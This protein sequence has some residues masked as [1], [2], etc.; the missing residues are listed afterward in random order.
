VA[1]PESDLP[2]LYARWTREL[3]GAVPP[4][5]ARATCLD[6][7]MVAAPG[8]PPDDRLGF[9]NPHTKCCT[10][11]PV[12]PNFLAGAILADEAPERAHGRASLLAR[13]GDRERVTPLGLDRPA[14]VDAAYTA[15]AQERFGSDASMRCPH[16]TDD[17]LCGIWQHRNSVCATWFCKHERGAVGDRFWSHQREWL[18]EIERQ[19]AV[20]CAL[21][22][23][24]APSHVA[25]VLAPRPPRGADLR[26]R[27][28]V[29]PA[30]AW[31]PWL[32]REREFY[33]ACAGRVA[34]LSWQDVERICGA[35]VAARA[36][37]VREMFR[38]LGD[39]SVPDRLV[40]MPLVVVRK[41]PTSAVVLTYRGTDLLELD[42]DAIAV[43]SRFDGRPT[44]DVLR[45]LEAED[46]LEVDPELVGYLR[47][48]DVLRE[49]ARS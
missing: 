6:C 10:Y 39:A 49:P 35:T 23:G 26:A 9:F 25:A 38:R 30:D 40:A 15:L 20:W 47:D 48:F 18:Q 2:P 1:E 4:R 7:A 17:G 32:G 36:A 29:D 22:S 41:T 45:A 33:V 24:L 21:G 12:L 19:L 44:K 13:I 46:D 43:V 34:A 42:R 27:H 3:L 5:E 31:G 37:A 11:T 14:A 16:M 28:A 8:T